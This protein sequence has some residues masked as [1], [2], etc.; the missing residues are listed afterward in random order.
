MDNLDSTPAFSRG[1]AGPLGKLDHDLKT[2]VDE[3][4]QRLFLRHCAM[5]GSDA[6]SVLRDCVYALV[7]GKTYQQMVAEKISHDADRMSALAQLIGPFQ[8][9]EFSAAHPPSTP[10]DPSVEQAVTRNAAGL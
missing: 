6:S 1:I 10:Y 7:H 9:P 8:G 2:K 5:R 4:T 3:H